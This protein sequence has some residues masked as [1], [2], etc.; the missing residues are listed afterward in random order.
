M[1]RDGKTSQ[2]FGKN[3]VEHGENWGRR[4]RTRLGGQPRWMY[5]KSQR[6]PQLV[7]RLEDCSGFFRIPGGRRILFFDLGGSCFGFGGGRG[8]LGAIRGCVTN[9]TT[10]HTQVVIEA[11]LSFLLRQLSVFAELVSK[12]VGGAG[13]RRSFA[14]LVVIV[15]V[16]VVAFGVVVIVVGG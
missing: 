16:L 2:K 1:R 3:G 14:G 11:A 6:S 15:V 8:S 13:G 10:E 5:R 9:S 4:E 7:R 12:R